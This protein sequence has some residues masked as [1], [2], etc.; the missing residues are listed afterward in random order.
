[1]TREEKKIKN[2]LN[3]DKKIVN[4]KSVGSGNYSMLDN[5]FKMLLRTKTNKSAIKSPF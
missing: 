5:C 2:Y 3:G 1:M 4:S